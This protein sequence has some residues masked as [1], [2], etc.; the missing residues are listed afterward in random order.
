LATWATAGPRRGRLDCGQQRAEF[1]GLSKVPTASRPTA[2]SALSELLA[3]HP[4][5]EVRIEALKSLALLKGALAEKVIREAVLGDPDASLRGRAAMLLAD[6][7][8]ET[9]EIVETLRQAARLDRI[10]EVRVR[11][12]EALAGSQGEHA[13][14]ALRQI[15]H[16][17]SAAGERAM[18]LHKLRERHLLEVS[19][20][21]GSEARS[22]RRRLARMLEAS[23]GERVADK[24]LHPVVDRDPERERNR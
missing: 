23:P 9:P 20:G 4:L 17:A 18:A 3:R 21:T 24:D 15:A 10:P 13:R 2:V 22:A 1:W 14:A 6:L 8:S 19:R 11:A 16:S 5:V 12:I 7:F